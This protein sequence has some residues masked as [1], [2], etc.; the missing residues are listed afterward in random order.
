MLSPDQ[1]LEERLAE[2]LSE[3][4]PEQ[5]RLFRNFSDSLTKV[6]AVQTETLCREAVMAYQTKYDE[7][8]LALNDVRSLQPTTI[9]SQKTAQSHGTTQPQETTQSQ[10][11]AQ[12]RETTQAQS[13]S[14]DKPLTAS[15]LGSKTLR[16]HAQMYAERESNDSLFPHTAVHIKE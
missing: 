12:S 14:G 1:V 13:S 6:K 5:Q 7:K 9:Q 4:T 8:L 2:H 3:Y 16:Q 11:T 15:R 10:E